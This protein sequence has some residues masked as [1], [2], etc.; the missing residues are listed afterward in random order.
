MDLFLDNKLDELEYIMEELTENEQHIQDLRSD[1][2]LM[3]ADFE[4]IIASFKTSRKVKLY[5]D[6]YQP[7]IAPA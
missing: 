3:S 2:L 1:F 4:A 7:I 6:Y 5:V